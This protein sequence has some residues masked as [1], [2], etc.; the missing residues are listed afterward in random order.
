MATIADVDDT[1]KGLGRVRHDHCDQ[2]KIRAEKKTIL[3][4]D[5]DVFDNIITVTKVK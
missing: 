2:S 4:K 1:A 5:L 3:R